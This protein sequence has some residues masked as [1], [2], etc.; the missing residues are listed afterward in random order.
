[1]KKEILKILTSSFFMVIVSITCH[2]QI[3]VD[4]TQVKLDSLLRIEIYGQEMIHSASKYSQIIS[5]A[6]TSASLVTKEEIDNFKYRNLI[7]LVRTKRGVYI[8]NDRQYESIGIRGFNRPSDYNNR[9]LLL[10]DGHR[11]NIFDGA[12]AGNDIGINLFNIDNVEIIRGP[13]SALYGTN[14]MFAVINVIPKKIRSMDDM[15]AVVSYGSLNSKNF[16]LNIGE[17]FWNDI[18]ISLNLNYYSSDGED[19]YFPEFDFEETNFGVAKTLD[20]EEGYGV[21]ANI[22]YGDLNIT[23]FSS[24]RRKGNPTGSF[25]AVFNDF[26]QLKDRTDFAQI[27]YSLQPTYNSSLNFSLFYDSYSHIGQYHINILGIDINGS[28]TNKVETYGADFQLM[29]D[30]LPNNRL[31]IGGEFRKDIDKSYKLSSKEGFSAGNSEGEGTVSVYLQNEYHFSS[32]LSL[33]VGLRLDNYLRD[34]S[35]ISPRITLNYS[36]IPAHTFKFIYGTAFR[37]P[38]IYEKSYEIPTLFVRNDNLVSEKIETFEFIWE[39]L[40]SENMSGIVSLYNYS[41]TNLIDVLQRE[42]DNYFQYYNVGKVHTTGLELGVDYKKNEWIGG[43]ISYSYQKAQRADKSD[44]TNSPNH[45]VKVGAFAKIPS[46]CKLSIETQYETD[47]LSEYGTKSQS[48]IYSSLAITPEFRIG[49]AQFSFRV[50]N[51]FDNKIFYPGGFQNSQHFFPQQ[52]R[53]IYFDL[54]YGRP[55]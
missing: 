28:A 18:S 53:T 24:F 13:G 19:I 51:L 46:I 30:V 43:Y 3:V 27:K 25:F 47:R 1:M 5:E 36:A 21:H 40:I 49:E 17:T 55:R 9:I 2:A 4:T 32:S 16:S 41:V 37:K 33:F 44:F 10:L 39:Y 31:I 12:P 42:S 35:T 45:L 29:W 22:Q 38:N 54:I 14:A 52:G 26:A 34:K 20:F 7:D 48:I 50:K 6:P 23:G 8:N 11:L 15:D